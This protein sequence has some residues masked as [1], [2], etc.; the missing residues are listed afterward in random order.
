[1]TNFRL[2]YNGTDNN[3]KFDE[4]D[5]KFPRRVENS[6]G[7]GGIAHY[8]QFLFFKQYFQKASKDVIVWEWVKHMTL[9]K[10]VKM[11]ITIDYLFIT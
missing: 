3:F 11:V 8:E 4:N 6:V 10:S 7:K 5:G 9:K 1:M 2:F